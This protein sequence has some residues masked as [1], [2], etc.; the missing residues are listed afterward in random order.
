MR[1]LGGA[2]A[3]AHVDVGTPAWGQFVKTDG[4]SDAAD[5]P[6]MDSNTSFVWDK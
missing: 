4:A 3:A 5:V 6:K 2:Q 1:R